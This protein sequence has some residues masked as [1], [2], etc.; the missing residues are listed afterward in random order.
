[1]GGMVP[2]HTALPSSFSSSPSPSPSSPLH[3]IPPGQGST[4]DC[5]EPSPPLEELPSPPDRSLLRV[6]DSASPATGQRIRSDDRRERSSGVPSFASS[7]RS[8]SVDL[9]CKATIATATTIVRTRPVLQVNSKAVSRRPAA[10]SSSLSPLPSPSSPQRKK[11]PQ[12]GSPVAAPPSSPSSTAPAASCSCR[13]AEPRSFPVSAS[14]PPVLPDLNLRP[15]GDAFSKIPGLTAAPEPPP[16]PKAELAPSP[17]SKPLLPLPAPRTQAGPSRSTHS[18]LGSRNR[19]IPQKAMLES[20]LERAHTAVTLDN[21]G[22][23]EG[24]V[25][26]YR[27][28]CALLTEVMGRAGGDGDRAQLQTIVSH[29]LSSWS[30]SCSACT[31]SHL[32]SRSLACFSCIRSHHSYMLIACCFSNRLERYIYAAD[33]RDQIVAPARLQGIRAI[34]PAAARHGRIHR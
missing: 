27:G 16:S 29:R 24:A 12:P 22:N 5:P 1:M 26:A 9:G 28:A 19:S 31:R 32:P 13:K 18:R 6:V 10:P 11:T 2:R 34:A 3:L 30:L 8:S 15:E 33:R 23:F 25:E 20:A 7:S 14:K 21:A 4:A 17:P